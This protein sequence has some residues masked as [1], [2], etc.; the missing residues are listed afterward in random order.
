MTQQTL[1]YVGLIVLFIVTMTAVIFVLTVDRTRSVS[2]SSSVT[3][4]SPS[5]APTG[6]EVSDFGF[7]PF[8]AAVEKVQT[9]D[10]D[11][12]LTVI[13]DSTGFAAQGWVEVAAQ[14]ITAE[15]GQTLAI[16]TWNKETGQYD[17][18][19]V[20]PGGGSTL[21]VWNGSAPGEDANYSRSN[22]GALLPDHSDLIVVN[23][24][25]NIAGTP[26]MA[27]NDV[28]TLV[29]RIGELTDSPSVAVMK[30]NPQTG[31]TAEHHAAMLKQIDQVPE[32]YENVELINATAAFRDEGMDGL[33]L[34]DGIHP[35]E[36]GYRVW[37][38]VFLDQL[39]F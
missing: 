23:H 19:R 11:F 16:H 32:A 15:T 28:Y 20:F 7:A 1:K 39:G 37:A 17:E 29:D 2:Q 9:P 30:Q 35:T 38:D 26:S 4:P 31:E 14:D 13:G 36:D 3:A 10:T 18:A 22:I 33:I 25:H 34:D 24:G 21:T 27:I 12:T 8:S 5:L 6:P